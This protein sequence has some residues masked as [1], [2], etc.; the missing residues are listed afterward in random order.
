MDQENVKEILD[1]LSAALGVEL[2]Q[3][4]DGSVYFGLDESMGASLFFGSN[5]E[6]MDQALVA[7]IAI[8][9]PADDD[10][11]FYRDLLNANY[12]WA[13]SGDGTLAIDPRSGILVLHRMFMLPMEGSAFVEA[14][15]VMVGAARDWNRRLETERPIFGMEMPDLQATLV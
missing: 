4:D 1:A 3:E 7:C 13:G 5:E 8:G 2:V 12:M 9:R 14:F 10:A 15:S 11:E 6:G